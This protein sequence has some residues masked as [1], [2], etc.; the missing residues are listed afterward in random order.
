MTEDKLQ[1][2]LFMVDG[3]IQTAIRPY[4]TTKHNAN[5]ID[6]NNMK[7]IRQ[8]RSQPSCTQWELCSNGSSW[9]SRWVRG[10]A[11]S[12]WGFI[13]GVQGFALGPSGFLDTNMLVLAMRKSHVGSIAQ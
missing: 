5:E 6:T 12:A 10:L 8:T 11:L 3:Q 1:H 7:S 2:N 13:L 9:G 4:S